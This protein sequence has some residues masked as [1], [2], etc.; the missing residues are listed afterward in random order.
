MPSAPDL[1]RWPSMPIA[2]AATNS[3]S[4]VVLSSPLVDW[5]AGL[6]SLSRAIRV[7]GLPTH[8]T[9]W[10]QAAKPSHSKPHQAVAPGLSSAVPRSPHS[11]RVSASVAARPISVVS[12]SWAAQSAAETASASRPTAVQAA[13]AAD[14]VAAGQIGTE[15]IFSYFLRYYI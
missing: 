14:Q 2:R 11:S 10:P 9:R 3:T 12:A 6:N 8:G 5:K 4:R 15:T 1:Q 13:W 7:H